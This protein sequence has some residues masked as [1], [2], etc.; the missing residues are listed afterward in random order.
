MRDAK[1]GDVVL[2]ARKSNL[3]QWVRHPISSLISARIRSS[4]GSRWSHVAC[5]VGG[6]CV[7]EAEWNKGVVHTHF[8]SAYSEKKYEWK[9]VPCPAGVDREAVVAYWNLQHKS[10]AKYDHKALIAMRVNA[11]LWGHEGIRRYVAN[12]NDGGA[13]IC[14]ELAAEGWFQG[15]MENAMRALI[16]PGDFALPFPIHLRGQEL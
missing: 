13:V 4:T 1:P 7:I 3:W 14:S 15:G 9:I 8:A 12:Q 16:V 2:V 6:G 5:Y 10:N 11:L